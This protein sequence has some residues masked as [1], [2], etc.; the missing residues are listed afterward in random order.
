MDNTEFI[1]ASLDEV[2]KTFIE[3]LFLVLIIVFIFLQSWEAT[4]IPMLAVPVSLIGTFAS[5][6]I[7][8]F[9]INTLTLFAMVLAIGL[10]VD[11]AI[12]VVEAVEHH[13]RNNGLNPKEATYRAMEEVSGPVVA[14]AFVLA[15]VFIP[16]AFFG[17]TAGVLYKQF[18]ITISVSMALSALVALTL[19]PA[20]CA[21]LL[22]PH[23]HAA[24]E[25]VHGG[26]LLSKHNLQHRLRYPS[27]SSLS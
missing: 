10:V 3:A 6:L 8:G 21:M 26:Y 22:K 24:E 5:F 25:P 9:T 12:V 17:G 13:I 20:L 27:Y 23:S 2:I 18:A 19:T 7:L 1:Q 11:D 15:S 14:I 4:L 16:V